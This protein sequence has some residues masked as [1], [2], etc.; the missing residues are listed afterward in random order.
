MNAKSEDAGSIALMKLIRGGFIDDNV[1]AS[2]INSVITSYFQSQ[3]PSSSTNPSGLP[4]PSPNAQS[5]LEQL[6]RHQWM[7]EV[8][9]D[10][11]R[12]V[13]ESNLA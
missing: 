10:S 8:P 7:H 6:L 9:I 13:A 4:S 5:S 3:L 2:I 11:Q 1:M 12:E